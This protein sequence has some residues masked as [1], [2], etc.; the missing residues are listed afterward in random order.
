MKV[1]DALIPQKVSN[2]LGGLSFVVSGVFSKFTRD[3]IKLMI[4]SHGG[5]IQ[6]GISAKTS[7]LVAGSESGPSKLQKANALNIP[8][9][10]ETELETLISNHESANQE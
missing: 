10:S 6:S 9:L 7:Y 3:E 2:N 5:K 1:D 4:E 8:V